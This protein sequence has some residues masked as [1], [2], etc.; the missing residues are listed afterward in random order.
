ML[1]PGLAQRISRVAP[2]ASGKARYRCWTR[3]AVNFIFIF[4]FILLRMG[5]VYVSI[6]SA[7][8]ILRS[9]VPCGILAEGISRACGPGPHQPLVSSGKGPRVWVDQLNPGGGRILVVVWVI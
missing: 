4:I 3:V 6:D 1:G 2:L 7:R 8:G 9:F 5:S